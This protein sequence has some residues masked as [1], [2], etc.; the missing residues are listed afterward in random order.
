MPGVIPSSLTAPLPIADDFIVSNDTRVAFINFKVDH[1]ELQPEHDDFIRTLLVPFYINQIESLGF[2]DKTM[3]VRPLGKASATGRQDHNKALS[4]GRANAV[5]AAIKKYFDLQKSRGAIAK[6]VEVMVKPIAEGDKEERDL[7]GPPLGSPKAYEEKSNRFRSVFLSMLVQHD[8]NEDDEKILC[9]QILNAKLKVTTVPTN[10]LEQKIA[11]L[12]ARMPA[13]LSAAVKEFL[14]SVK[15]TA[16]AIGKLML[17]AAEFT[18]PEVFIVL[19]GIEFIVPS[20]IALLFEFKDSRLRTKKY[21][22]TGSANK[23]DISAIELFAQLLSILKWM[24]RL[25]QA[26]QDFEL[27]LEEEERKLNLSHELIDKVKGALE[28]ASKLAGKA[29]TIFDSITAPGSLF[30]K[31]FGDGVTD[32]IVKAVNSGSASLLGEAELAT[33]FALVH[34]D[35]KGAFDIFFFAGAAQTDTRERRG[36]PTTIELDFGAPKNQP[37]LGFRGHVMMQRKFTLSFSIGSFEISRGA[38]APS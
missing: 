30:R 23:I 24:T 19:K 7:I 20:D 14:D 18:G 15:S 5:G 1:T 22:F 6:N 16:K 13:E 21:T 12:Q 35:L 10:L 37:L 38:L 4:E 34:F 8:V 17:E 28:K 31:A 9:R 2:F 32:L 11:D 36:S 26:L 33:E 29:K 27:E 25:P 3:T